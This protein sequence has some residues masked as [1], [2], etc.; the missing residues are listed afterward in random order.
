MGFILKTMA[1]DG[2]WFVLE[3]SLWFLGDKALVWWRKPGADS[4]HGR[5]L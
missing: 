5:L 2:Y 4:L 1:E 3:K